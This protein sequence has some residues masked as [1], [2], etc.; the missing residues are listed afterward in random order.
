M[1]ILWIHTD[2]H[3][4]T[5]FSVKLA[6]SVSVR[7]QFRWTHESEIQRVEEE[8]SVAGFGGI[9]GITEEIGG[10]YS[11]YFTIF[12]WLCRE[13]WSQFLN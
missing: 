9:G 1:G 10:I 7:G 12:N 6:E 11:L 3:D 5:A 13:E 2:S 8:K 4:P